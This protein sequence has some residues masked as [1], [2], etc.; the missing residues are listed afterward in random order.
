MDN[1]PGWDEYFMEM[2][3]LTARPVSYTH[4]FNAVKWIVDDL[5]Y[6]KEFDDEIVIADNEN[7]YTVVPKSIVLA[8]CG[9]PELK[10]LSLIH[11]S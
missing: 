3:V 11:I 5:I 6:H 2:A 4:L 1:R 10:E 7:L 9:T 8:Y